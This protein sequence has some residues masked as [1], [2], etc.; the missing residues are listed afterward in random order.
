[1]N[2]L[3]AVVGDGD[4]VRIAGTVVS[5]PD[6]RRHHSGEQIRLLVRPEDVHLAGT[7]NGGLPGTVV[8][9]IF[10]G[11]TSVVT[12]RLDVIDTLVAAHVS[13]A[14]SASAE[15]GTRVHVVIDGTR[16]VCEGLGG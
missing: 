12:A 16:A 15:P 8:S 7:E 9:R 5:V 6:S 11:A 14:G 1:M 4:T 13:G 3:D 2:E 10:Q